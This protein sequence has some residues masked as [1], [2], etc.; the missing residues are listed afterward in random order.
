MR[1][2]NRTNHAALGAMIAH[3]LLKDTTV[4]GDESRWI[5]WAVA[6]SIF[7]HHGDLNADPVGIYTTL[8]GRVREDDA[9]GTGVF[10]DQLQDLDHEGFREWVSPQ[11]AEMGLEVPR[12]DATGILRGILRFLPKFQENPYRNA[13]DAFDLLAVFGALVAADKIQTAVPGHRTPDRIIGA[14]VVDEFRNRAFG[15]PMDKMDEVRESVYIQVQETTRSKSRSWI[16]TLTAPTGSGKTL[17][18]LRAGLELV[19]QKEKKGPSRLVYCLPFTSVIDQNYCVFKKVL[20]DAGIDPDDATLLKHHHLSDRDY[21]EENELIEDGADLLVETWQ[22]KIVV[23]TFHQLLYALFSGRNRNLKRLPALVNAVV[24]LDEVQ[25]IDHVYWDDVR[26]M[27]ET[28][29]RRLGTTFVLMTATMPLIVEASEDRELVPGHKEAYRALSRT[30]LRNRTK[31][32]MTVDDLVNEIVNRC[33][34]DPERS[35]MVILNRR[36]TVR[37]IYRAVKGVD[38]HTAMLSTDLTPLDRRRI[39]TSLEEPYLLIT[40]QVVEAGVDISA[41]NVIRDCAPLDSLIQSAGRCNRHGTD[42]GGMLDVIRLRDGGKLLAVPPYSQ[43][44]VTSSLEVL[45]RYEEVP[46]SK[47][48]D[49]ANRYYRI[50]KDRS[51]A[52]RVFDLLAKGDVHELDGDTGLRLIQGRP[53]RPFFIIQSGED[54]Q[55]WDEFLTIQEI[56]GGGLE[57]YRERRRRF[58][59]IRRKFY[60]RLVNHPVRSWPDTAERKWAVTP[61]TPDLEWYDKETGLDLGGGKT[62][63]EFL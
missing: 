41:H 3:H 9:E 18:G 34:T 17:A 61:V 14:E 60:E 53:V 62:D 28:C 21:R 43:F 5:H 35:L 4:W 30:V 22:S 10:A 50:V 57:G 59:R 63:Y 39:L 49:L 24:L 37:E 15:P 13:E 44:L 20:R 11:L 55:I 2:D 45:E 58:A 42:E 16:H 40:T 51:D 52:A 31:E 38:R 8:C 1:K 33:S 19:R 25:A 48:P 29:A 23:T 7:R 12:M 47:F 32:G 27:M 56:Q 26:Q 6:A 54:Q 36:K 46:E